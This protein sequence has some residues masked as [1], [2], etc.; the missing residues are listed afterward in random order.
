[1]THEKSQLQYKIWVDIE[2]FIPTLALL[3]LD[4]GAITTTELMP[5][6]EWEVKRVLTNLCKCI[7]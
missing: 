7:K 1:M 3:I 4:F 2:I 6:A 5:D